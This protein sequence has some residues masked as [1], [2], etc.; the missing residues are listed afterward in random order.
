M[1][2][3]KVLDNLNSWEKNSFI[4]IIGEII[5]KSPKKRQDIDKILSDSSGDLKSIDNANISKVFSHI[6]EEFEEYVKSVFANI[7]SQYDLLTDILSRDGNCILKEDWFSRLYEK[8]V[9]IFEEKRNH[10]ANLLDNEKSEIDGHRKRD[11][12]I[13]KKC[14]I[15]AY[16]NDADNNL[17][18]KITSDEQSIFLT[19]SQQLGL[20]QEEIRLINYTVVPLNKL[21]VETA[22]NN[23]KNIGVAFYSKKLRTIYVAD[24]IVKI[25]RKV[26]GKD[27][28]DKF[29]RRVL[30]LL[31]EPQINLICK[32]YNIDRSNSVEQKIKDIISKGISFSEV[33]I[34]DMHKDDTKVSEKKNVLNELCEKGLKI[35]PALKGVNIDEKVD[36]LILY[37]ENIER[38]EK[39]SISL[40]RYEKLLIEMGEVL[41]ILNVMLRHEFEFP[42]T[43][44]ISSSTLLDYNIK[45]Q[46]VLEIIPEGDLKRFCGEKGIKTRGD[47]ISNILDAYKDAGNLYIENYE[48]IGFRNFNLLKEN[49]ILIKEADIGIKFEELTKTIFTKLGFNVDESLRKNINT[50][51]DKIDIVLNMGN[52]EVILVECKTVKESGYNKFSSV[53]RQIKSYI[54][55]AKINN[56]KVVKSLLLAPDF[57]D[58]FV[59]DCGLDYE[60]NLSL[61][62]ASTLINILNGFKNSKLKQFPYNLL[63]R[64]VLIQ[65]DRVLKAIDK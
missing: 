52:N 65:E 54:D 48:N 23:L 43:T 9:K 46:D 11:Y 40:D 39:V 37:F 19:L 55:L 42:E 8:E 59:K 2:L 26:K 33:L 36:N 53:S 27:V 1:K 63:M 21:D 14:L 31:R 47:V 34:N 15:T 29:F 24:E 45:P 56:L 60:L 49:G 13:Y 10:F 5:S 57:S 32:R 50:K 51:K 25:L 38:D 35:S 6:E 4:G 58:E 41:P 7:G 16:N 12:V 28:A 18:K 17:E 62:K 64:D 30:L 3:E 20:S 44:I 61:L 22:I